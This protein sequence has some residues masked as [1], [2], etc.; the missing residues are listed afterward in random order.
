MGRYGTAP[1]VALGLLA[2][3]TE[4]VLR[5]PTDGFARRRLEQ[6]GRMALSCYIAQN[7]LAS[8]ICYGWGSGSPPGSPRTPG[9]PPP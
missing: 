2:A 3:I 5:R 4:L 7:L 9:C 1:V 8:V 6:I